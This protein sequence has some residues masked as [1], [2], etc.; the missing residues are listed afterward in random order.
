MSD[1]VCEL[2]ERYREIVS[3][4]D[5]SHPYGVYGYYPILQIQTSLRIANFLSFVFLDS[6]KGTFIN[7]AGIPWSYEGK[8]LTAEL[9]L[10]MASTTGTLQPGSSHANS[11]TNTLIPQQSSSQVEK[12]ILQNGTGVTKLDIM[13]WITRISLTGNEYLTP[14]DYLTVLSAIC[15][16]CKRINA[17]RKYAFYLRLVGTV[18]RYLGSKQQ[19]Q[20]ENVA[21]SLKSWSLAAMHKVSDILESPSKN[22]NDDDTWLETYGTLVSS[23][24]DVL[25]NL[26]RSPPSYCF[27]LRYGW[28]NLRIG[29][30]KEAILLSDSDKGFYPFF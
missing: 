29:I 30:L 1:F 4:Y 7:C 28:P 23:K 13:T 16:I 21:Y 6:F 24:A 9:T 14:K 12:A 26:P 5:K 22:T 10:R 11:V 2:P 15:S 19:S 18:S 20:S 17:F 8:S 27:S 25:N 3:L